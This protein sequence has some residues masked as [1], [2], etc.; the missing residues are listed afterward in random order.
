MERR[1]IPATV[2]GV[3]LAVALGHGSAHA[4]IPVVLAPWANLLVLGT[5]FVG[6]VAG[7][8]LAWRGHPAGVPLFTATMAGAFLLGVVLHFAVEGP[9][10]VSAIPADPWRLPFRLTAVALGIVEAGGIAIGAWLWRADSR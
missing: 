6:P 7:A 2:A 10:H 4:L 1:V 5:V 8:A 9:D 3:H